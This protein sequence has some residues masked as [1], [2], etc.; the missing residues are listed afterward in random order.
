MS[1]SKFTSGQEKFQKLSQFIDQQN[2]PYLP[3]PMGHLVRLDVKYSEFLCTKILSKNETYQIVF[4]NIFGS[5]RL[6]QFLWILLWHWCLLTL[7]SKPME[8]QLASKWTLFPLVGIYSWLKMSNR[9]EIRQTP[10]PFCALVNF[11]CY[12]LEILTFSHD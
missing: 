6:G 7:V 4:V 9:L 2:P 3:P 8:K 1:F 5:H 10:W 12:F 11:R